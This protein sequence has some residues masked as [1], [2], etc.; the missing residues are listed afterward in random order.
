[1][2]CKASKVT[3]QISVVTAN[4]DSYD[5]HIGRVYSGGPSSMSLN[6]NND[7][8]NEYNK[9]SAWD[10]TTGSDSFSMDSSSTSSITDFEEIKE[11]QEQRMIRSKC[12]GTIDKSEHT[13]ATT[14]L[15]TSANTSLSIADVDS[16]TDD[17]NDNNNTNKTQHHQRK[18]LRR[19]QSCPHLKK[20]S[21]RLSWT[22]KNK[23]KS[24]SNNSRISDINDI[25]LLEDS[26]YDHFI[27]M[28]LSSRSF[29]VRD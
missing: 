26:N 17:E 27:Q 9:I 24:C 12:I 28:N 1:M 4:D 19:L 23:S 15:H 10:L 3:Y 6:N 16:T 11:Q 20:K 18:R 7:H 8:S 5:Y 13:S 14:S 22:M 29:K 2:G 25:L 21:K